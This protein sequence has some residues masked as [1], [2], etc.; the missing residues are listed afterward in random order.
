MFVNYDKIKISD[1][2]EYKLKKNTFISFSYC[3]LMAYLR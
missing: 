2:V 3:F 1:E